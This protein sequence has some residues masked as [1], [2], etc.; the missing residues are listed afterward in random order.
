MVPCELLLLSPPLP[1]RIAPCLRIGSYVTST[2]G[3]SNITDNGPRCASPPIDVQWC[4]SP[5]AIAVTNRHVMFGRCAQPLDPSGL[6]H[7][8]RLFSWSVM[9]HGPEG[10]P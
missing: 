3:P 6:T 10:F 7:P 8:T 1:R 4:G 5:L 2:R 9:I